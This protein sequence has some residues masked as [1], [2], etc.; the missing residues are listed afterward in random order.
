MPRLAPVT[1]ATPPLRSLIDLLYR[2]CLRTPLASPPMRVGVVD[3]G[4]NSTRLLIAD[5][6]ERTGAVEPLLRR[7][8]VTRLGDGVDAGGSLSEEAAARVFRTL[9]QYRAAI[10][11]HGC[12][13]SLAVL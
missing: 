12:E 10:D 5:V 7:S 11:D 8:Q 9:A 4:S 1:S 2:D 13:K 3:I 6:E